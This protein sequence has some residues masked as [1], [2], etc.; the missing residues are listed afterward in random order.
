MGSIGLAIALA[1]QSTF[2]QFVSGLIILYFNYFDTGD[3]IQLNTTLGFIESF[4]LF[5]TTIYDSRCVKTIISNNNITNGNFT[6]YYKKDKIYVHFN[7]KLSNNNIINYDILLD[8]IKNALI[9]EC[10]YVVDKNN[11]FVLVFDMSTHCTELLIRLLIK[12]TDYFKALFSAQL[13]V[14]KVL[15]NDNV[16]LLDNA[17]LETPNHMS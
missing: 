16:L 3:L 2:T 8:N 7:V 11:V 13:I 17:Y 4:N 12:N 14:R 6:N 1:I 5:N 9:K 10:T 15:A